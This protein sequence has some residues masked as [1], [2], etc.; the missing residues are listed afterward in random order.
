MKIC[1]IN[2]LY[3]PYARGGA[4]KIAETIVNGLI[5]AGHEVFIITTK[6]YSE[7]LQTPDFKPKIYYLNS[8]Y[9]NL[10]KL[11][12]F[13][14]LVW[15]VWDMFDIVSYFKIKKI[16]R[17]EKCDV[18]I[19]NNL[20]GLGFLIPLAIRRLKLKHL[21]LVHDIQLI[22]PSGLMNFG[23]E[24]IINGQWAR[25]YAGLCS[26]LF[27]SP[28]VVIFPSHW[29]MNRYLDRIF[30][31]KSKRIVLPNPV[32]LMPIAESKKTEGN[33]KFLYLGQIEKH[34]GL[35][36]L[37]QACKKVKEKFPRVELIIAGVGSDLESAKLKAGSDQSIKFL[38]WQSEAE[39]NRLLATSQCLVMPT[40]CY[41]N[42]PTVILEAF[43]AGLPVVAADLGGISELIG[44]NACLADRQAGT[45]FRPGNVVDLVEKMQWAISHESDLAEMAAAGRTK[46]A[47]YNV[48][49]YIKELEGLIG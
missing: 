30:F 6:P 28:K 37:I 21:H 43:S 13:L 36:L 12:K 45:L 7:K 2:N 35:N 46:V 22:H 44:E 38:G 16:L 14:R 11:P 48:E 3:K 24:N 4:E 41:E 34:K 31:I 39:V 10:N 5:K 19:T 26:Q 17:A 23:Q 1:L 20:M 47:S 8:R 27:A 18:V 33:F 42:C 29:L 9:Y 49:N 25:N 15:H 40:L 32:A